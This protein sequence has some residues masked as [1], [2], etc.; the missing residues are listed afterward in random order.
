VAFRVRQGALGWESELVRDVSLAGRTLI[1]ASKLTN[2]GSR[3]LPL[4]WFAHP[5]FALS[6]GALTCD[7]PPG[8]G[9]EDNPGFALD[10]AGRLAFKRRFSGIDDGHYQLLRVAPGTLLTA[11]L[12]H[13]RLSFVRFATD[14]VPD[15]CPVWGNG[16]TWSIEPYIIT[17]LAPGETRSWALRYEFGPPG[18]PST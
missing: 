2:E 4:H 10:P 14:F 15:L 17:T 8:Y 18:R 1:S 3:P 11:T 16:N 6:D 12:S 5:F 9:C 7:L 13:P